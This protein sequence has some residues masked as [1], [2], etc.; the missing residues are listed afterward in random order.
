MATGGSGLPEGCPGTNGGIGPL[1]G[2]FPSTPGP[3]DASR[4]PEEGKA[5][6]SMVTGGGDPLE[7]CPGP[8]GGIGT[9]W[10]ALSGTSPTLPSLPITLISVTSSLVINLSYLVGFSSSEK[11]KMEKWKSA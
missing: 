8:N 2:A 3:G 10:G 11:G 1:W 9:P 6:H 5:A 4:R 7:A